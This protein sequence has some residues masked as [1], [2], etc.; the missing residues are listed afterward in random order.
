MLPIQSA[1]MGFTIDPPQY[2]CSI[3]L[4][5]GEEYAVNKTGG[6]SLPGLVLPLYFTGEE[7]IVSGVYQ[8]T[9][10]AAYESANKARYA[11]AG[12]A[13]SAIQGSVLDL[14]P[15]ILDGIHIVK[16]MLE[17]GYGHAPCD[18]VEW[19]TWDEASVY[20]EMNPHLEI[21][22]SGNWGV[23]KYSDPVQPLVF[24]QLE[25][26]IQKLAPMF[27]ALKE[28]IT[29]TPISGIQHRDYGENEYRRVPLFSNAYIIR[30]SATTWENFCD[31]LLRSEGL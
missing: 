18:I 19:L 24:S 15:H 23:Y 17:V 2:L 28:H 16:G 22:L 3:Y 31:M 13:C 7:W 1:S 12:F 8:D 26:Y 25:L 21:L 11:L 20:V 30:A 4:N 5:S 27:S 29:R 6:I 9:L 10:Q 14:G